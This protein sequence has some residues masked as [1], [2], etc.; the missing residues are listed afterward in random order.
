MRDLGVSGRRA[1]LV[2][3]KLMQLMLDQERERK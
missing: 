3:H 1:W 2:K